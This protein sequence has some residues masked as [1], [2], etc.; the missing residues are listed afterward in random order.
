MTKVSKL[1]AILTS[2]FL[3]TSFCVPGVY[4]A[5]AMPVT[6]NE[7]SAEG[8]APASTLVGEF[9]YTGRLSADKELGTVYISADAKTVNWTVGRT[10]G[11]GLVNLRLVSNLTGEK[12]LLSAVADNTLKSLTWVTPLPY[13][14]YTVMVEY[15]S[16]YFTYDTDIYFYS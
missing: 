13:G 4:A 7:M 14:W 10:G 3:L 11:S 5:P 8:I 9:H 16:D 2:V 15:S 12:R 1:I 6:D